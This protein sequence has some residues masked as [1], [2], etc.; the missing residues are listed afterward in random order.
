MSIFLHVDMDAFFAAVEELDHPKWRN[1][2]IIIGADPREGKGRGVVSTASYAA[3][4]FGVHSAMPISR[5]WKLCPQGIYT[6]PRMS[7]Y[8]EVSLKVME[9]FRSFTPQIQPISIDEA[10]LDVTGCARLF[11]TPKT[12]A[13]KVKDKVKKTTGL[14]CSVGVSWVKSLAKIASDMDKPD[15]LT[16]VPKGAE[17]EFLAPLEVRKLWGVGP[18]AA[19]VMAR[20]NIHFVKDIQA[21][22]KKELIRIFGKA[23]GAHYWNMANAI[24][25]REVHD[26][27][28]ELSISHE[29]TFMADVQDKDTL[30]RTLVWLC[31][32]VASRLRANG[33]KGKVVTVKY[34]TEDFKTFTRRTTLAE[35]MDD[36]NTIL[37]TAKTLM[38]GLL[39]KTGK[40]R[41]LG[42]G[43]S[44]FATSSFKQRTLF[45]KKGEQ[46]NLATEDAVDQV[47]KR[48]GSKAI[49]RGSLLK[50]D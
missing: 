48:F 16:Y 30:N 24:D 32:K 6:P 38:A 40:V 26:N 39:K 11:G 28:K 22:S 9:V 50:D 36:T 7:R 31:D 14:T 49:I 25:P 21:R 2:P 27:V 37:E 23:G 19:Q 35:A 18:K 42:V 4:V 45:E 44:G 5:A 43:V 17:L 46:R 3:R 10:F 41:L 1:K 20:E 13:Q 34:R 12:I 29:T 47:R 15:G 33:Q 8:K